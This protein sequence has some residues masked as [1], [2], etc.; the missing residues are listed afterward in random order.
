MAIKRST[1]YALVVDGVVIAKGNLKEIRRAQKKHGGR[2]WNAPAS[3]VGW[4]DDKAGG[5]KSNPCTTRK[6][7]PCT[8]AAKARAVMAKMAPANY[9]QRRPNPNDLSTE[10]GELVYYAETTEFTG[11]T[12]LYNQ[13]ASIIKNLI[14][15]LNKGAYDPKLAPK[16]WKY[17]YDNAA[18]GYTREHD[19]PRPG[20]GGAFGVF[21]PAIRREAAEYTAKQE[22]KRILAGDYEWLLPSKKMPPWPH[23]KP[24][25]KPHLRL[26]PKKKNPRWLKGGDPYRR[27]DLWIVLAFDFKTKRAK[28]L[29]RKTWGNYLAAVRYGSK[30]D[31][32]LDARQWKAVKNEIIAV[33]KAKHSIEKIAQMIKRKLPEYIAASG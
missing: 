32:L 10:A 5:L 15:K 18:K 9:P 16:L 23:K 12:N 19:V 30:K 7:N 1:P 4:V 33:T 25:K 31:A 2:I 11:T 14:R 24:R 20:R 21:T 6:R 13:R 28:Y 29:G 27:A 26:V 3:R 8:P 17:L 22:L